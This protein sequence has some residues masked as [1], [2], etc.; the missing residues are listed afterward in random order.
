[1]CTGVHP[2][3]NMFVLSFVPVFLRSFGCRYLLSNILSLSFSSLFPSSV[4]RYNHP[5][6]VLCSIHQSLSILIHPLFLPSSYFQPVILHPL[7]II[8]LLHCLYLPVSV[9][10]P[11]CLSLCLLVCLLAFLFVSVW[12][13]LCLPMSFPL[14]LFPVSSVSFPL[15]SLCPVLVS[16]CLTRTMEQWTRDG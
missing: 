8:C 6:S 3:M 4:S 9:C 7:T 16:C 13:S 5:P 15:W 1:M 14:L 2:F 11:I 10:L 12:H